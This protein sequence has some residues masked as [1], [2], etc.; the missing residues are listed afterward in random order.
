MKFSKLLRT[1]AVAAAAIF[2][3]GTAQAQTPDQQFGVGINTTGSIYA[4]YALNPAIHIG[5]GFS[6]VS[7]STAVSTTTG[8]Q[9][10]SI[11]VPSSE[12]FVGPF[13]KFLFMGTPIFKP[14]VIGQFGYAS[15]S[16]KDPTNNVT[17][18]VSRSAILAGGGAEY[19]VS[20]NL[21]IYA[22]VQLL[23]FDLTADEDANKVSRKNTSFG[24]S[25]GAVGVEWFF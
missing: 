6:Y 13:A 7:T 19:F 20:R 23:E 9:T 12:L 15:G 8:S 16:V 21:G 24:I 22:Q 2:A 14:F 4:A 25:N 10:S 11:D 18:T 3:F 1:S 17:T 5:L